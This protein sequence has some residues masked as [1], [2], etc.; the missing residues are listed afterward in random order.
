[1]SKRRQALAFACAL[2]ACAGDKAEAPPP[3]PTAAAA[4]LPTVSPDRQRFERWKEAGPAADPR[5]DFARRAEAEAERRRS[6]A[7]G[8]SVVPGSDGVEAEMQ[9]QRLAELSDWTGGCFAE[10]PDFAAQNDWIPH[11]Q[12]VREDFRER[13]RSDDEKSVVVKIPGTV[14]GAYVR[15]MLACVVRTRVYEGEPGRFTAELEDVRFFSMLSRDG[16]WWN[17]ESGAN[18]E[19]VLRHEQ[20]HFDV[21]ELFA[22]EQNA[23]V[24]R[25]RQETR[26]SGTH[27]EG[28]TRAFR[29]RLAE[30]LAAQ[31]KRF[32]EVEHQYDRE[33]RHGTDFAMQT[34]WFGRVK[35]GLG[36]VRAGVETGPVLAK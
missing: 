36:A 13:G 3:A 22:A 5:A 17:P 18:P 35:R 14:V 1:M 8:R 21:A 25:V 16:S 24:E 7:L 10:E 30:Y 34:E 32:E 19:W 31:Q 28:A 11:R 4:P 29:V 33:T 23:S 20:L 2:S 12:L 15:V 9:H 6:E 26:Q 27:P